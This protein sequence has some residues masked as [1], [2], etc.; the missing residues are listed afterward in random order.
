MDPDPSARR[1]RG[2][3]RRGLLTSIAVA[4]VALGLLVPALAPPDALARTVEWPSADWKHV[5]VVLS[6]LRQAPPPRPV[7]PML[8]G[9]AC[10]ESTRNDRDWRRQIREFAG[11]SVLAFNLGATNQTFDQ[12]IAMVEKLPDGPTMV[13]I[14]INLGR[15]TQGQHSYTF[16]PFGRTLTLDQTDDY[17]QHSFDSHHILPDWRK[18]EMVG[19]WLRERYPY[20]KKNFTYNAGR[21]RALVALCQ[22]RGFKVVMFNLPINLKTVRPRLDAPRNRYRDECRAVAT[23]YGVPYVDFVADVPFVSRDFCD[24][25]HLVPTGRVKWQRKLSK[26]VVDRLAEY[27]IPEPPPYETAPAAT[28]TVSSTVS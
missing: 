22:Q 13:L 2:L 8:G 16:K 26:M 25:W 11:P 19:K 9:S 5:N 1:L 7:V 15:F 10:R 17:P 14:G 3:T 24:N 4:T 20:F 21:L 27:G 28:E 6:Y 18:R 23:E 12:N